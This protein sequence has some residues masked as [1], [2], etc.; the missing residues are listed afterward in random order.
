MARTT[1]YSDLVLGLEETINCLKEAEI[2][3]VFAMLKDR[4][5]ALGAEIN[6]RM[7]EGTDVEFDGR[8][9][10]V[11]RGTVVKV[12]RVKCKVHVKNGAVWTVPASMLRMVAV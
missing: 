9:G 1:E 12:N 10:Q 8:R 7:V 11:L 2:S 4:R 5:T 3:A 6:R